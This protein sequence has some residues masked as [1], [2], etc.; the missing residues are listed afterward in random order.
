MPITGWHLPGGLLYGLFWLFI[1]DPL[2]WTVGYWILMA[3]ALPL[4][5]V[6]SLRK[7]RAREAAV[8]LCTVL[9]FVLLLMALTHVETA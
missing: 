5:L 4:G 8:A 1:I 9:V 6:V 2:V 7:M 3:V